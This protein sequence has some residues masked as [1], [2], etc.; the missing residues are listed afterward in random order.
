MTYVWDA[1]GVLGAFPVRQAS[2]RFQ[3]G[4]S[5]IVGRRLSLNNGRILTES[6]QHCSPPDT[7]RLRLPSVCV[8]ASSQLVSTP[9]N[10]GRWRTIKM[11]YKRAERKHVQCRTCLGTGLDKEG[12]VKRIECW[13]GVLLSLNHDTRNGSKSRKFEHSCV[14]NC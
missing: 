7:Q 6:Y 14:G 3:S 9:L 4:F 8:V 2:E 11:I 13:R 12:N 5:N 1:I 10:R